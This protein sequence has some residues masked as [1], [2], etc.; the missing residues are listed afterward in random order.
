M[1]YLVLNWEDSFEH[2]HILFE[3]MYQDDYRPDVIVAIARGGWIPGRLIADFFRTKNTANVK[4]DAYHDIAQENIAP[5]ITQQ[6]SIDIEDKHVL[7]IDDIADSGK[8]LQVVL[9]DFKQRKPKSV[10]VAT[11]FY[12]QSSI[13]IPDYYVQETDAWVIFPFE[14]YESIQFFVGELKKENLEEKAI[15]NRLIDIGLPVAMIDSYLIHYPLV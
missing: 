4:V 2:A 5:K 13:I 7:I 9:D 12:K 3:K 14:Y 1:D 15:R 11:I 6:I 8:S 10:K